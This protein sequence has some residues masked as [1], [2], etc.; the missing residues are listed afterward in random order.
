MYDTPAPNTAPAA[1][2]DPTTVP[3]LSAYRAAH[4]ALRASATALADALRTVRPDDRRRVAALQRWF[5]GYRAELE[6]HHR[7]EDELF[8]PALD[9]RVPAYGQYRAAMDAD[10]HR[11]D[12]TMNAL[13]RSLDD[14]DVAGAAA[15]AD[16]LDR[17]LADH[18]TVEDS[19]VLPMF[20]RHFSADEYAVLDAAAIRSVP[21]RH[22]F[23]TV[24]W[25]VA[26]A[27]ADTAA[28]VLADAPVAMRIVERLTRRRYARLV[29]AA[30]GTPG[31]RS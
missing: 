29:A 14:G 26:T 9:A 11:L 19:D 18:L 6:I 31:G 28:R 5:T 10:H 25:F 23:F 2:G 7:N 3:D 1:A 30:F 27:P 12:E 13:S 24:P 22:A 16:V 20:E 4:S 15:A 17:E 21:L 8:F